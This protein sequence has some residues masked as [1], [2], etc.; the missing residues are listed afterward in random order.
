MMGLRAQGQGKIY[1]ILGYLDRIHRIYSSF[2]PGAIRIY[3]SYQRHNWDIR[4]YPQV[5]FVAPLSQQEGG[6]W[7]DSTF[8]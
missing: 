5:G 6:H 7:K 8:V 4:I 1:P 3:S 2:P